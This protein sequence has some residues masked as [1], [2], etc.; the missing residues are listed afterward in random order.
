MKSFVRVFAAVTLFVP[1]ITTTIE[2]NDKHDKRA[3]LPAS[4]V[5]ARTV[6]VDNQTTTAELQNT[7]YTN[8]VKFVTGEENPPISSQ[9]PSTKSSRARM[10]RC[11]LAPRASR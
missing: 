2:A 1:F 9:K 10:K 8:Y 3:S 11:H 6:Y 5:A 4:V 7:A